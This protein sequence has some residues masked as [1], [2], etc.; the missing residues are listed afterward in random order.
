MSWRQP[1]RLR[2]NVV[3]QWRAFPERLH[4][5]AASEDEVTIVTAGLCPNYAI[6]MVGGLSEVQ[7]IDCCT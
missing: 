4:A 2:T 7:I 5:L 1:W 3:H 6:S